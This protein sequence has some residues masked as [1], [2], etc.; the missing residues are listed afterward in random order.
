[1]LSI[2][3]IGR[4]SKRYRHLRRYQHIIGVIL[5]YGF[6]NIIHAMHIDQYIE[7]GLQLIPFV[8][9]HEKVE[10][11]TRDQRIRMA[12]EELG[13]TFI[14]MGQVLSSRPD[15]IPVGLLN[16]L[17]KLQDHVP[18]FDF[19]QV[20]AIIA[21]EFGKSWD[22]IFISMDDIPFA[23]ASI[24]QVHRAQIHNNEP[25]A[26]KIQK[27]GIRKIIEVDLEIIRHIA[28]IM[29]KNIEEVAIFNPVRIVQEFAMTLEKELDYSIEAS[30][31]E[32]MAEQFKDD[33]TIH[34]PK[35]FSSQSSERVL[36]MEYISGI[37]ADDVTAID[38]A[39]LDRRVITRMGADF[40]MKQVFE[41]G[42]FHADPHPGNI[43]IL[44]D[45]RICP[46]DFGMTGFLDYATR[47]VFVDLV[48]SIAVKNFKLTTR[49]ICE[50]A[51]YDNRPDMGRLEKDIAE[52]I[53]IHLL[54]SLKDIHT[55][56]M[57]NRFL[58]LCATHRLR[59]PPDFFLMIKAFISIEGVT[60]ILNPDFDMISHAI[61]YMKKAKLKKFKPEKLVEDVMD[62][63]RQSLRLFKTFP[64]DTMEIMRLAK[65][66]KLSFSIKIENLDRM[67][68]NQDQTSN[69]ISFSIVIAALILGSAVV[70][71][72]NVP[73]MLFG[74]S[75]IGIAGFVA[76]AV[77]G[78]WL[79]LAIISK[80]RL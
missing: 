75:L 53:S 4:I 13:P 15:L 12:L 76:A 35:V 64:D 48:Y 43:F 21:S 27:P 46:V 2:K 51:E 56:R 66:G 25:V 22:Q 40:V 6:D 33:P 32:R 73:P 61:P 34:I 10:K 31:M 65:T 37:K 47:E 62:M 28:T 30:S 44:E 71:N 55:G 78:I 11:L 29:E 38:K 67:L 20:K 17:A 16:E 23:S 7:S 9:K 58:E 18:P 68:I 45:N 70:I 57:L 41:H 14:K 49:L 1:M 19:D 52:F 69:R 59:I 54:K 5:K 74:V 24:G 3:T 42:F 26:V 63:L 50:L 72:S 77:M 8:D 60:R 80:G 36:T 79:L 39:G